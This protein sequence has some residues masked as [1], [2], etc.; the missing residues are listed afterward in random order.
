MSDMLRIT[1]MGSGL[2]IDGIVQKLMKA[3]NMK[4]DKVKQSRQTVQWKQDLFRE[5]L[6][7]LNTFKNNY[8]NNSKL[9]TNMLRD[10]NY[11]SFD[12][13]NT[14]ATVAT[15]TP[16]VTA[17]ASLGAITGSYKVQVTQLAAGATITGDALAN[18]TTKATTLS[19]LGMPAVPASMVIN[20]TY[21]TTTKPITI[22][23]TDTIDNVIQNINTATS[24]AVIANFSELT[25]QFTIQ[26]A[27][28]GSANTLALDIPINFLGVTGVAPQ[29]LTVTG[30][31]AMLKI[32]PPGG[33]LPVDV[34]RSS[35]NF[36]IDSINYTLSKV[37]TTDL[38][39]NSNTQKSFDKIKTFIDKYNELI[40]KINFKL[41]E[42]T[43]RTYTPLTDD[44]KKT[45]KAEEI[46]AWESKAKEGLLKNDNQLSN[47]VSSM[48]SA[49]YEG[50]NGAGITLGE[51]GLSTS[52][53]VTQR[54]VIIIDEN[55]L[56]AALQNKG[57]KVTNLF[58][59][60]SSIPYNPD[61][62][63]VAR[64]LDE[65]VF[66][67]VNDILQDYTRT[68]RDS[69]GKKGLLL[70]KAG[71]KGDFTEYNNLLSKQLTDQDIIISNLVKKLSVK[72]DNYYLKFS[73]LDT[74]MQKMNSQSSW[75]S[76]QMGGSK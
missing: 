8:F 32:T 28:I 35:N 5:T 16:G 9:D 67:K 61:G 75:L 63:N 56:K 65:G 24:G 10:Y 74:A 69:N 23:S 53:D 44:Q 3:E 47:M 72:E 73:R 31:D 66:Q 30:K 76:Q 48:R 19:S 51:I 70:E 41:E 58:M 62:N 12:V 14:D 54:G 17:K 22:S 13:T 42:K 71:I 45:M 59:K 49:F 38:N 20:L 37:S 43:Q 2:D 11:S 34:T 26:T 25:K 15:A 50:V 64:H 4:V 57:D 27:E 18:G 39:V 60:E 36:T 68:T 1:G 52:S 33:T 29:S 7:D 40:S 55:K 46:T 6:G 21:G